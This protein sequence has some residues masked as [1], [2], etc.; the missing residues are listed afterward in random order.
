M[1]K[2]TLS[3]LLLVVTVCITSQAQEFDI[4]RITVINLGDGRMLFRDRESDKPI[5]GQHRIIDGYH[6]EYVQA[7]FAEGLY[8]GSYERYKYNKLAEKGSYK[9]GRRDGTW[10]EY[11]SDGTSPKSER[12][13]KD[14]KL[15]GMQKTF[16]TNG[17][18]E[19]E[20]GYKMGAED[21]PE[22]RWEY[23]TGKQ[24][25]DA[26]Y[27]DDRPEGKQ[28]RHISSNV[29]E[30]TQVSNYKNGLQ[31]GEYSETW[32]S[33]MLRTKGQYK[34]GKKDGQWIE[35]NTD[36]TRKLETTYKAGELDG[37]AKTYYTDGTVERISLYTNGSRAGVTKEFYYGS[38]KLK[39]EYTYADGFK[40]GPYKLYYDDGTVREE[41][42]CESNNPVYTKEFY[43][44]GKVKQIRERNSSGQWETIEQYDSDGKQL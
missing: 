35:N 12:R 43:K 29:G 4:S 8:N 10:F 16:Y 25:V 14:G 24:T 42:R 33:G 11:N 22:R 20:K 39:N 21:G 44:N 7:E 32:L 18:L 5:A 6:S 37:E 30:Y 1:K 38:G 3:L 34:E 13:F 17:K 28:T 27:K 36:G 23:Q 9:E 2:R 41:G 26:N 19:S 40:S 31:T 15:D